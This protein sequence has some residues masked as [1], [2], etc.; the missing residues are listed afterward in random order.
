MSL[1]NSKI[2]HSNLKPADSPWYQNVFLIEMRTVF[3]FQKGPIAVAYCGKMMSNFL[4][5]KPLHLP[6]SYHQKLV[7]SPIGRRWALKGWALLPIP[8]DIRLAGSVRIRRID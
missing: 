5:P 7:T 6:G 4:R 3:D 1:N 2:S 8:R